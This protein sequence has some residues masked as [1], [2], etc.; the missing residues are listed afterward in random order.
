MANHVRFNLTFH[1]INDAAKEK[2]N[3]MYQR[4]RSST[5]GEAWFSDMFVEGDLTYEETEQYSWTT[6]HIGPKWSYLEE[7]SEQDFYGYSAWSAPEEGVVKLLTIL[8]EFDPK[9]VSYL[10]YEDEGPNFYGANVYEG[11]ELIDGFEEEYDE[12]IDRVIEDSERLTKESYDT[13]TEEWADDES[14]DIFDEEMWEVINDAQITLIE[15]TM[16]M[17]KDEQDG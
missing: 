4:I 6:E 9:I 16:E 12:V 3:E 8:S 5:D 13:D 2:L 11:D 1:K 10:T 7:F 15:R 17:I 14:R